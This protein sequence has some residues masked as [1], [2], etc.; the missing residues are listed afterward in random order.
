MFRP[1]FANHQSPKTND[2]KHCQDEDEVGREP[3]LLLTFIE[4]DLQGSHA[5]DEQP[6]SPIVDTGAFPAEIWRIEDE[7]LRKKNSEHADGD[8]DIEDPTPAVIIGKP[9]AQDGAQHGR[10]Y[11]S[12]SPKC[13]CLSPFFC[14]KRFEENCL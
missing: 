13:H 7:G 1:Q 11:N 12:Q 8:I 2:C 9:A 14:G 10:D 5:D 6:N 3:V 4:H